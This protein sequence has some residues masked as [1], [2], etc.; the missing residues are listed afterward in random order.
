MVRQL[1]LS[2]VLVAGTLAL[3]VIY[4][5]S[6]LPLLD[7]VGVLG[8]LGVTPPSPEQAGG[9]RRS[10][11]A[12]SVVVE[13]V[14]EGRIRDRVIAI[15][16]GKALR[17]VT[18]R[19]K[20][21]GQ[22]VELGLADG[23]P[24]AAGAMLVRFDDEAERI[25]VERA[26]LVLEDAR[27][28]AARVERL[29]TSGAVTE[30][31]RREANLALR[32]AELELRQ[33]EF[34]LAERMVRAPFAGRAGVLDI[35]VGD[36]VS[37]GD[38]LVTLT[39]RSQ[40]LIDFHVPARVVDRVAPGMP[41]AA[42]PLALP[43]LELTGA[44]HAVDNI[45]D[46][47]SRTLRVQGRLDNSGDRL[48]GGMAFEVALSFPG[49][50]LPRVDPLAVQWSSAGAYVWVVRD[51]KAARVPVTIRQRNAD[52]VLVEAALAPGDKVVTE[53]VQSLREG[54]E[55]SIVE[56]RAALPDAAKAQTL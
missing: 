4:V 24:V 46:S 7:R 28:E 56:P 1:L 17:T 34:D 10:R 39:D 22:V 29:E 30:V 43:E 41:L 18:L 38:S 36:R 35:A 13:E 23:D 45:V 50:T 21:T 31:R 40:I 8:V 33:A 48:R 15:G 54:A 52:A 11:G 49:E 55:V 3:W 6:A 47:S 19:A 2:F 25:A 26:R 42:R 32:T 53:G 51:G 14:E 20:V 12:A 44:V 16:D 5:P 27:D 37:S 9:G